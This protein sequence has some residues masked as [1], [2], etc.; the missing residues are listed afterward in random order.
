MNSPF[1]MILGRAFTSL[2]TSL[3][4]VT[5]RRRPSSSGRQERESQALPPSSFPDSMAPTARSV[6]IAASANRAA[7]S[8]CRPSDGLVAYGSGHFV[9]LWRSSV[10]SRALEPLMAS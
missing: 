7:T 5:A 4:M 6:Y 9:A 3:D 2:P 10:R 8:A 1:L